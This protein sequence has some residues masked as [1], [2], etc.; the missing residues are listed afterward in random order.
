MLRIQIFVE[1]LCVLNIEHAE[2][3]MVFVDFAKEEFFGNFQKC[4]SK[5]VISEHSLNKKKLPI[6]LFFF[7]TCFLPQNRTVINV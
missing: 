1:T 5:Y 6:R 2:L 3:T 7:T 4:D